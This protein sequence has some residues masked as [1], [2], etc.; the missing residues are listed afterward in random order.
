MRQNVSYFAIDVDQL[1]LRR[2]ALARRLLAEISTLLAEG[3]IRPL[4]H[5]LFR[6]SEIDDA[7]RLMQA[8]GHIGKLVLVPDERV[9][10]IL[11]E[12]PDFAAHGDGTYLVTGGIDGFGYERR[13]GLLRTAPARLRSSAV[14]GGKRRGARRG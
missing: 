4:A 2:P 1:P 13:A 9:G 14:A 3:A 8:S 10:A 12:P 7:L 11:C 5:R 6:F